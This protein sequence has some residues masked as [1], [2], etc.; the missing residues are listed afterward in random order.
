MNRVLLTFVASLC[1][2]VLPLVAM[3][4]PPKCDVCSMKIDDAHHVH[5]KFVRTDGSEAH[6]GSLTCSEKFWATHKDENLSFLASDFVSGEFSAADKG[7]F[8]VGSKLSVGTGMDRVG[9]IFF[10]DRAMAEKARRANGGKVVALTEAL[11][12]IKR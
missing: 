4:G 8:L 3:A 12:A 10:A 11:S 5:F 1:L 9:A 6:L 7:Y 2:A